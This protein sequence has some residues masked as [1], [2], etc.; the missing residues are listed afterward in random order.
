MK[1]WK[2]GKWIRIKRHSCF[3]GVVR[4]RLGVHEYSVLSSLNSSME[5]AMEYD[6]VN[7]TLS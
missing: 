7:E 1:R 6:D 4:L 2:D 5:Y 3:C